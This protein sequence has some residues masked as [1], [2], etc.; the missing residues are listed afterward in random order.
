M[1]LMW[2]FNADETL[3]NFTIPGKCARQFSDCA[4]RV[5]LEEG[6]SGKHCPEKCPLGDGPVV[7][8]DLLLLEKRTFELHFLLEA[9]LKDPPE[10]NYAQLNRLLCCDNI[11]DLKDGRRLMH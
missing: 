3:G 5:A 11:Q 10:E 2:L 8:G 4:E 1:A 9:Q 6:H 7:L